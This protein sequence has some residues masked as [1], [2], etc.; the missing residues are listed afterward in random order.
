MSEQAKQYSYSTN[1]ENYYGQY[2]S[3]EA[4]LAAAAEDDPDLESVWVGE[5]VYPDF[6]KL[7]G[8]WAE[9]CLIEHV[10]ESEHEELSGEWFERD[11]NAMTRPEALSGL[12]RFIEKAVREWME[13]KD[14]AIT[15]WN[16]V[17]AKSYKIERKEERDS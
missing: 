8:E 16:V 4:A 3:V 1:E 6:A 5:N 17:N 2:D 13:S 9:S 15:S 12:G 7:A 11:W 14:L 10:W